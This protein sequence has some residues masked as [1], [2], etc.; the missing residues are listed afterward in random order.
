MRIRLWDETYPKFSLSLHVAWVGEPFQTP[1]NMA[2]C[3]TLTFLSQ[4]KGEYEG[5]DMRGGEIGGREG[6][7]DRRENRMRG[8]RGGNG[9]NG[10]S[11]SDGLEIQ[12]CRQGQ[13]P[14]GADANLPEVRNIDAQGQEHCT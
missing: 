3:L 7:G 9:G 10:Y 12:V 11:C 6:G 13:C 5:R 4:R 8:I 14:H 2:D 1:T